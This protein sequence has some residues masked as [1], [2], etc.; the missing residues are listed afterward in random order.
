MCLG[1]G[2]NHK[3]H[4]PET[5]IW[6]P[7]LK[8]KHESRWGKRCPRRRRQAIRMWRSWDHPGSDMYY[9]LTFLS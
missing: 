3:C 6:E 7:L 1:D 9:A 8:H 4:M 5:A 2:K